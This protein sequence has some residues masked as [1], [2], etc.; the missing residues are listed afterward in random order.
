MLNPLFTRA[1]APSGTRHKTEAVLFLR[2]F[3]LRGLLFVSEK[4][5]RSAPAVLRLEAAKQLSILLGL[6]NGFP[7]TLCPPRDVV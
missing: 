7:A 5:H 4:E 2:V 1:L 6:V 3:E